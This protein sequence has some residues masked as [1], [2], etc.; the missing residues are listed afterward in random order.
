MSRLQDLEVFVQVVRSG[1]FAKAAAELQLN[2]SAISRRIN[3][4]EKHLGVRL[5]NRSTRSL[6]LTEVG[7]RYFNRCLNILAGIEEAEQEAR[8]HSEEPQGLLQVSCST[9]FAY[10]YILTRI[11]EFLNQYP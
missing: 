2:P 7:E 10:Q 3:H 1:N 4:L 6:S 9:F 11:S 5:F 8:Q